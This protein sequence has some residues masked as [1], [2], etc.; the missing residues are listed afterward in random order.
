MPCQEV[1]TAQLSALPGMTSRG[2]YPSLNQKAR[3]ERNNNY[4]G[5]VSGC[6]RI[7]YPAGQ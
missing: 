4:R 7:D 5:R 2:I 3:S 1:S 6:P